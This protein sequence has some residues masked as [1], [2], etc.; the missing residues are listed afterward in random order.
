M[1]EEEKDIKPEDTYTDE[2]GVS[3]SDGLEDDSNS[4]SGSNQSF[5][6]LVNAELGK[7]YKS[8][9]EALK[10]FK[11]LNSYVGEFGKIKKAA[12]EKG[13]DLKDL[14]T[15]TDANVSN[16]IKQLKDQLW[17]SENAEYK[18]YKEMI[19]AMRKDNQTLDE[20]INSDTFKNTFE[21]IKG[22][23]EQESKKSVLETNPKLGLIKSKTEESNKYMA[24]ANKKL[25]SGDAQGAEQDYSKAKQAAVS[26]VRDLL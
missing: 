6:D 7:E 1:S 18:P 19:N 12:E 17:F 5:K 15:N 2:Q 16:D 25:Y 20:V 13:V 10:A 11:E 24:E 21:K 3:S 26:A 4:D 8:D 23:D 9:E 22:Y 14:V